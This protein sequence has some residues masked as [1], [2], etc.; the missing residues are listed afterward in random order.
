[1]F[2]LFKNL[3]DLLG[4]IAP[5]VSVP[6]LLGYGAILFVIMKRMWVLKDERIK[7]A[8]EVAKVKDERI[9]QLELENQS[10]RE[11]EVD[12]N[13]LLA[14]V[15]LVKMST[16]EKVEI[17]K[18]RLDE[19]LR[20][21]ESK[22][23]EIA[24]V[25]AAQDA[26]L[27]ELNRARERSESLSRELH[28]QRLDSQRSE[29][30][31]IQE[32]IMH[33]ILSPAMAIIGHA[34]LLL[35][36]KERISETEYKRKLQ[37]IISE[38][39]LLK[40]LST[41]WRYRSRQDISLYPRETHL[42]SDVITPTVSMFR[43]LASRHKTALNIN[44]FDDVPPLSLDVDAFQQ[45]L[46]NLIDNAIKHSYPDYPVN[47]NIHTSNEN[48]EIDISNK[49]LNIPAEDSEKIFELGFRGADSIRYSPAGTG[50]GLW[51]A[52]RLLS[53][54]GCDLQLLRREPET[55]FRIKI[56]KRLIEK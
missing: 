9:A 3:I 34:E 19:A 45:A 29:L 46:F 21:L 8:Q 25:R 50:F 4:N 16:Q 7:S 44:R 56:P 22:E 47:L 37:D 55:V 39:M 28:S 32:A 38:C 54:Q 42:K 48:I 11:R 2:N 40:Q 52:R 53:G 41:S 31:R 43:E 5:Y 18:R 13:K 33:E 12:P 36:H 1:M 30:L 27:S 6:L 14:E 51:V 35:K 10:L 26:L 49:G 15:N 17:A 23:S 24:E 20:K